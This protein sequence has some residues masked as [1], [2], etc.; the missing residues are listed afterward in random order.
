M[1][2]AELLANLRSRGLSCRSDGTGRLL[3][4]PKDR[5]TAEDCE[6]IKDARDAIL[7]ILDQEAGQSEGGTVTDAICERAWIDPPEFGDNNASVLRESVILRLGEGM[8]IVA[9]SV[10]EAGCIEASRLHSKSVNKRWE[11]SGRKKA[12]RK[13]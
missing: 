1:T 9:V 8:P 3:I 2:P 11:E 12:E 10:E 5:L 13:R 6:A 4:S 7:A